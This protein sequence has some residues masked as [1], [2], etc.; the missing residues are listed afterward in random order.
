MYK[1]EFLDYKLAGACTFF[2][3][4][5]LKIMGYGHYKNLYPYRK[6]AVLVYSK[7][8]DLDGLLFGELNQGTKK[9]IHPEII[10][11]KYDIPT[12]EEIYPELFI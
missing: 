8:G 4:E 9:L 6:N 10:K 1:Q 3:D 12:A 5:T 2:S 7:T 11:E